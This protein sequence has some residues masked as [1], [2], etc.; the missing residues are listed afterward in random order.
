MLHLQIGYKAVPGSR[1]IYHKLIKVRKSARMVLLPEIIK[2][3]YLGGARGKY[4]VI[5][6]FHGAKVGFIKGRIKDGIN[7]NRQQKQKYLYI[8]IRIHT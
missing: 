1:R 4:D 8:Q 7:R 6:L 5:L 2:L 3:R